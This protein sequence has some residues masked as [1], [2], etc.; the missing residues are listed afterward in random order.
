M[1]DGNTASVTE[2]YA[3]TVNTL[4]V[5][6][7]AALAAQNA[8]AKL[9]TQRTSAQQ[10]ISGVNANEEY[11]NLVQYQAAYQASAKVIDTATTLFYTLLGLKS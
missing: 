7:Q 3:K 8:Q 11:T 1:F 9:V 5:D 4:G 6:A 10:A 2:I